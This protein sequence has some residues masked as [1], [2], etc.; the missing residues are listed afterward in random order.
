MVACLQFADSVYKTSLYFNSPCARWFE[1][2]SYKPSHA[3]QFYGGL[4]R[5]LQG[6]RLVSLKY[7]GERKLSIRIEE[8]RLAGTRKRKFKSYIGY[9]LYRMGETDLSFQSHTLKIAGST[10][11]SEI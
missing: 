11:V 5:S 3:V 7:K 1:Q 2:R 6:S 9:I 10:P 4:N 8:V